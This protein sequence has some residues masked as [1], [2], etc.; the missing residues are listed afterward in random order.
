[1][2]DLLNKIASMEFPRIQKQNEK[3]VRKYMA[4]SR[5]TPMDQQDLA[6][7]IGI[8]ICKIAPNRETSLKLPGTQCLRPFSALDTPLCPRF[9]PRPWAFFRNTY[10]LHDIGA[11]SPVAPDFSITTAAS[12]ACEFRS[13]TSSRGDNGVVGLTPWHS[14]RAPLRSHVPLAGRVMSA[15]YPPSSGVPVGGVPRFMGVR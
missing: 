6:E 2:L 10:L 8:D 5:A 15:V 12:D 13:P 3:L 9:M 1:M 14:V 11:A 4:E 7:E